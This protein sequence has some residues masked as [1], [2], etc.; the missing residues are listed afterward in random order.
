MDRCLKPNHRRYQDYGGRGITFHEAWIK[1][2]DAFYDHVG[3]RPSAGHSLGRVDNDLGYQPGN[4]EWQ[5]KQEQAK[6]TRPPRRKRLN[7]GLGYD[8]YG[9]PFIHFDGKTQT[10]AAWATEKGIRPATLYDR[11]LADVPLARALDRTPM[12]R[13]PKP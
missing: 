13:R 7:F 1:N 5:T 12:S 10:M 9:S 4:L 11:L 2:F 8:K 3:A 6:A